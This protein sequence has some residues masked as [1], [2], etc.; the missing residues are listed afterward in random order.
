MEGE[1]FRRWY[2][3]IQKKRNAYRF[4]LLEL[5]VQKAKGKAQ[6]VAPN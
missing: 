2:L 1:D 6:L 3:W 5:A 4:F